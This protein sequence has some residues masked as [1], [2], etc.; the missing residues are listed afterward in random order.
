MARTA[1]P[2]LRWEPPSGRAA[3]LRNDTS[4]APPRKATSGEMR[5]SLRVLNATMAATSASSAAKSSIAAAGGA[6][7]VASTPVNCAKKGKAKG[8]SADPSAR[9]AASPRRL[10]PAY[11]TPSMPRNERFDR[12]RALSV[13]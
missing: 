2:Q 6:S 1:S 3:L 8:T 9:P 12:P 10:T 5:A 11:S 13:P 7:F 4:A